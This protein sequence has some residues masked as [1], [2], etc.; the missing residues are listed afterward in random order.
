MWYGMMSFII[1]ISLFALFIAS[2]YWAMMVFHDNDKEYLEIS[3]NLTCD[4]LYHNVI[5]DEKNEHRYDIEKRAIKDYDRRC[6]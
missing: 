3:H 1:I 5:V 6:K 4:E 2:I